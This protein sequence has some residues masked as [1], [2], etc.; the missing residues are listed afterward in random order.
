[1]RRVNTY[2]LDLPIDDNYY[3]GTLLE[4][5]EVVTFKS[6]FPLLGLQSVTEGRVFE[7]IIVSEF[8][9]FISTRN[10]NGQ[11]LLKLYVS[12]SQDGVFF[13]EF[14]TVPEFAAAF[15]DK[16]FKP[17]HFSCFIF[18]VKNES[19]QRAIFLK[20]ELDYVITKPE[21]TPYFNR[22]ATIKDIQ[23]INR[24]SLQWT[25][26]VLNKIVKPGIVPQYIERAENEKWDDEDYF[27][28]WEELIYIPSLWNTYL[29]SFKN[30]LYERTSQREM[31]LQRQLTAMFESEDVLYY[32]LTYYQNEM[33]RRGTNLIF[34]EEYDL[35]K[36]VYLSDVKVKGEFL[37]LLNLSDMNSMEIYRLEGDDTE[38][39]IDQSSPNYTSPTSCNIAIK[40]Y[41]KKVYDVGSLDDYFITGNVDK[42]SITVQP[43][44]TTKRSYSDVSKAITTQCINCLD[45]E[46]VLIGTAENIPQVYF[47]KL[48][49]V[50]PKLS[51]EII[52]TFICQNDADRLGFGVQCFDSFGNPTMR[53]LRIN[54]EWTE[55]EYFI[56]N[57]TY[58]PFRSTTATAGTPITF[59]GILFAYNSP[60]LSR[61]DY[62]HSFNL[63]CG[64]G[65]H[66]KFSTL[67]IERILPYLEL[68][69]QVGTQNSIAILDFKVRLLTMPIATYIG[70]DLFFYMTGMEGSGHYSQR[71]AIDFT[72]K[73]LLPY[74][75]EI[76]NE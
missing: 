73:Y 48:I 11:P 76:I 25:V 64:Y 15:A 1:M 62:E 35:P 60:P 21:A 6:D 51:Y 59:R 70:K 50:N 45:D 38:W 58:E 74:S 29:K 63:S 42:R 14:I 31:L 17:N 47:D 69:G 52:V 41:G 7:A 55:S 66:L 54:D 20:L 46:Q 4:P 34:S 32:L 75:S 23:R 30:L 16:S 57:Y 19:E 44:A 67:N 27:S 36:D 2:N 56:E 33:R 18:N 40:A 49:K 13:S 3:M 8:G 9:E 28:F 26:N 10:N 22:T 68:E 71:E 24:D 5:E 43:S 72:N 39:F 37:R 61:K 65:T 12:A 53:A